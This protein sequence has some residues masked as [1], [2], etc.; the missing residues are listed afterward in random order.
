VNLISCF[1]ALFDLEKSVEVC[2]TIL[3]TSLDLNL[4]TEFLT[5]Y[6][7]ILSNTIINIDKIGIMDNLKAN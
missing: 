4:S 7:S 2:F 1:D 3:I 5:F 6:L